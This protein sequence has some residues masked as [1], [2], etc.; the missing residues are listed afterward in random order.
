[1]CDRKKGPRKKGLGCPWKGKWVKTP[2]LSTKR[3][4]LAEAPGENGHVLLTS[5]FPGESNQQSI[6]SQYWL[7]Q[8]HFLRALSG[9]ERTTDVSSQKTFRTSIPGPLRGQSGS[10]RLGLA[11]HPISR[12]HEAPPIFP[13]GAPSPCQ[14]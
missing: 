4:A 5:A 8:T 11:Q 9:S 3:H 7:N 1:M 6:L 12:L 14:Q 10:Q 13:G 2:S